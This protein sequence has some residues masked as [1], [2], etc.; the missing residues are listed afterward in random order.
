MCESQSGNPFGK[1]LVL[2]THTRMSIYLVNIVLAFDDEC[3]L[4]NKKKTAK[5]GQN[6]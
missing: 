4:Y 6:Y 3:I 5:P 2:L 1:V